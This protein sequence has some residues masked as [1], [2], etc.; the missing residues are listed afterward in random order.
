M[1]WSRIANSRYVASVVVFCFAPV[2]FAQTYSMELIAPPAGA[3]MGGVYISPYTA[4]IGAP[5]QTVPV[6]GGVSTAVICDDFATEVSVNTPPWQAIQTNV[7]SLQAETAPNNNLKFDQSHS[8]DSAAQL[9]AQAAQQMF[10]Y[11]VA[12]YLAIQILNAKSLGDTTKQGQLSF[13]LWGLFDAA[14]PNGPLSGHWVTGTN[15]TKATQY[16]AD[17][18]TAVT[19]GGL[20]PSLYSNVNIYTPAPNQ[21]ASQEY[22]TVSMPEPSAWGLLG[23]DLLAVAGGLF[24]FTRRGRRR[25][26]VPK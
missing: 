5:G 16:L 6:I 2:L 17:A 15:L 12:A 23:F 24:F 3:V 25:L 26:S 8:G 14:D 10:D 21:N 20:T 1:T 7:A 22:I 13:A 4:I 18:K 19:N 9:A 11:T